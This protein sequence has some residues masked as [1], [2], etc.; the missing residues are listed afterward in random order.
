MLIMKMT[1]LSL[2]C[3]LFFQYSTSGVTASARKVSNGKTPVRKE[4]SPKPFVNGH[5]VLSESI[6]INGYHSK[7]PVVVIV[8]K[9]SHFTYVLQLQKDKIVRILRI[10]NA[11]GDDSSPTPPGRYTVVSKRLYPI[12]VPP[13][14][15]DPDQR[16]VPPYNETHKNPLGVAILTLNKFGIALHGTNSPNKIRTSVSHGCVRHSNNDI[17]KLYSV[18]KPGSVVY[19]VNKWRG[20]V[21]SQRDFGLN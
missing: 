21:L 7:Q 18:V 15:I 8:D 16:P 13:K 17:F 20:K 2:T 10:S 1:I 5:Y 11:I 19:I 3:S 4:W 14:G 9:G 12:W 6:E